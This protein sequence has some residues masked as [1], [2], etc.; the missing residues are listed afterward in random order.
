MEYG[1]DSGHQMWRHRLLTFGPPNSVILIVVINLSRFGPFD[2]AAAEC[3]AYYRPIVLSQ[4]PGAL[5]PRIKMSQSPESSNNKYISLKNFYIFNAT[6]GSVEGEVSIKHSLVLNSDRI[7]SRPF[8]FSG[9][10]ENFILLSRRVRTRHQNQ[11]HRTM[12]SHNKIYKVSVIDG[13]HRLSERELTSF[14]LFPFPLSAQHIHIGW[15]CVLFAH[16]EDVAS[17]LSARNGFLDGYGEIL[18]SKA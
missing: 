14:V 7:Q 5:E 13:G 11:R 9:T 18:P 2:I 12:W 17:L 6:Y 3:R 10:K 15:E 8:V 16:P 1:I 4:R